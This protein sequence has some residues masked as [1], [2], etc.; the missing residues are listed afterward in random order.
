[1]DYNSEK[2]LGG[3][4]ILK[5]VKFSLWFS[6]TTTSK[7]RSI[8]LTQ[9]TRLLSGENQNK[10]EFSKPYSIVVTYVKLWKLDCNSVIYEGTLRSLWWRQNWV[11]YDEL[12]TIIGNSEEFYNTKTMLLFLSWHCLLLV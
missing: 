7:T 1:M 12:K 11:E 3:Y 2:G 8:F 6:I 5:W 10:K 9:L 4:G